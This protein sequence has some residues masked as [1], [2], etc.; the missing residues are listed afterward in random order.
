MVTVLM[1]NYLLIFS[2]SLVFQSPDVL[3]LYMVIPY[4]DG[5]IATTNQKTV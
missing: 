1:D 5:D 2:T 3:L 4:N